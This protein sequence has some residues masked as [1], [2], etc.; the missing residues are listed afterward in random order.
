MFQ[1]LF[2][3]RFWKYIW[4]WNHDSSN[5]NMKE[6]S[7]FCITLILKRHF[8]IELSWFLI[9]FQN[10]S[11]INPIKWEKDSW[12]NQVHDW[13]ASWEHQETPK[14]CKLL[15]INIVHRNF[16]SSIQH[17]K[18]FLD[19]LFCINIYLVFF[20]FICSFLKR[21]SSSSPIH[22]LTNPLNNSH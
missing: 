8:M 4:L 13:H 10:E 6:K 18:I 14:V 1:S 16:R 3:I 9:Y 21:D 19:K 15:W 2:I 17:I 11:F 5:N 22:I 20:Y 12:S 7:Y